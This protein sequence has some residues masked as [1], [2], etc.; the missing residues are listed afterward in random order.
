MSGSLKYRNISD[1]A[2]HLGT[3]IIYS[4]V[5]EHIDNELLFRTPGSQNKKIALEI[6]GPIIKDFL[7]MVIFLRRAMVN[8]TFA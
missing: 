5:L 1:E 4:D 6:N 7:Q 2:N 8:Q 3:A